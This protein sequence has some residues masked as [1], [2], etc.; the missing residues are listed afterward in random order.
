MYRDGAK[1]P[2]FEIVSTMII[3]NLAEMNGLTNKRV[4]FRHHTI[5]MVTD[6][7]AFFVGIWTCEQIRK[8]LQSFAVP[9]KFLNFLLRNDNLAD[10]FMLQLGRCSDV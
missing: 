5:G 2:V 6:D 1:H 4:N 10:N 8:T 9:L 7:D 3:T